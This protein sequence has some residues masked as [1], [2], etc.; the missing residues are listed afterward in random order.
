MFAV[1]SR[2]PVSPPA[3]FRADAENRFNSATVDI[4]KIQVEDTA[5]FA[6]KLFAT[7]DKLRKDGKA[8]ETASNRDSET[9][10]ETEAPR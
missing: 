6:L 9:M 7:V 3:L 5:D 4:A 8:G 1:Q 2:E 10:R